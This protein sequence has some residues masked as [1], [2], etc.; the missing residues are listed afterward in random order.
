[1]KFKIYIKESPQ[2]LKY[3]G[4][5]IAEDVTKYRGS[6]KRWNNHL[7]KNGY[8]LSDIKT[9]VIFE[10]DSVE[11]LKEKGLYYSKLYN[12]VED[13]DW[14][15]LREEEGAGGRNLG[16]KNGRYGK[17][18]IVAGE[19]NPMYGR[20]GELSPHFGK[21]RP[22]I[23]KKMSGENHWT[24]GKTRSEETRRKISETL[25]RRNEEKN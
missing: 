1:M 10:T 21:K 16:D 17:G 4:Q 25:K 22:E 9:E 19:N 7:R 6:G 23:S 20:R 13:S 14:A 12:V 11:E 8:G 15:N 18:Y 2:G 3:L 24:Y 5:T